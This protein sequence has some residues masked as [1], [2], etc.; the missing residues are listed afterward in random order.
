ME[1]KI[2]ENYQIN[3]NLIDMSKKKTPTLAELD[4]QFIKR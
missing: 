3:P 4:L 1:M 2:F